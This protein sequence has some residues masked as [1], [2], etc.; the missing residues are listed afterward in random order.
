MSCTH[1]KY[2][3]CYNLNILSRARRS[4]DAPAF[5]IE[6]VSMDNVSF[7]KILCH[8][9]FGNEIVF[10]NNIDYLYYLA[11]SILSQIVD[12]ETSLQN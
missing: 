10:T 7:T 6:R 4:F 12:K 1:S 5:K 8:R 3:Y 11:R 9:N 2:V